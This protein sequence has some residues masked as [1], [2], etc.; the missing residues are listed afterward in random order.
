MTAKVVGRIRAVHLAPPP[1]NESKEPA[2]RGGGGAACLASGENMKFNTR[3]HS[4]PFSL[5]ALDIGTLPGLALRRLSLK[6]KPRDRREGQ[7]Y[8]GH[9]LGVRRSASL[10]GLTF[11]SKYARCNT[12]RYSVCHGTSLAHFTV[13]NS[14]ILKNSKYLPFN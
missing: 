10:K 3:A 7:L 9:A 12:S 14:D 8:R 5:R 2:C 6:R 11:A 1:S 13:C 4:S